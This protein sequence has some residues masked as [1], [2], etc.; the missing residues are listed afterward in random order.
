MVT[1]L[2]MRCTKAL[3]SA[4]GTMAQEPGGGV[5]GPERQGHKAWQQAGAGPT[6]SLC[7]ACPQALA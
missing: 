6:M 3:G 2:Q 5:E 4:G 7:L 1:I